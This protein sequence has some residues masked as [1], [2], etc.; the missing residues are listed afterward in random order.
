[1]KRRRHVFPL[2]L[3]ILSAAY[4]MY[5]MCSHDTTLQADSIGGDPGGKILPLITSGFMCLGF[6]YMFWREKGIADK[7]EAGAK[8]LFYFTLVASL[9]YV[10]CIRYA[11]FIIC[12]VSLL[13]FL[14]YE[15]TAMDIPVSVKKYMHFSAGWISSLC[16]TVILYICMRCITK[17]LMAH[18][19]AGHIPDMFLVPAFEACISMCFVLVA[20]VIGS[21]ACC[22]GRKKVCSRANDLMIRAAIVS[23]PTV[24]IL[25]IVFKQF[26]NVNL[27]SGFMRL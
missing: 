17:F 16:V 4:F 13:F 24:L 12:S 3:S 21:R 6:L 10:L 27:P 23:V 15:Y 9:L 19:R 1:M 14:E 5:M 2:I 20:A 7:H 8:R 22:V 18:A 25:Y 11:G 26:F